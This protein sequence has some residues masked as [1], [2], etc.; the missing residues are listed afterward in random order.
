VNSI[1]LAAACAGLR[2]KNHVAKAV[3]LNAREMEHMVRA[4]EGMRLGYIPSV[5]N[6]VCVDVSG[7]MGRDAMAVYDALLHEGIIVRPVANYGMPNHL[8]VTLGLPAENK[9]FL[10]ALGKVLNKL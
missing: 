1:A 9:M 5:G 8:R 3:A 10:E 4:F 6:F 7:S 2:D